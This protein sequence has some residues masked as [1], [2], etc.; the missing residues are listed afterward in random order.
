MATE[1]PAQPLTYSRGDV[2]VRI[3]P[4]SYLVRAKGPKTA[5]LVGLSI[6]YDDGSFSFSGAGRRSDA[7]HRS[8][9]RFAVLSQ[10]AAL[11]LAAERQAAFERHGCPSPGAWDNSRY[12]G[13]HSELQD[14]IATAVAA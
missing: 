7:G 3:D 10:G 13:Y 9:A 6:D 1:Q 11:D 5:I 12:L 4:T 2:L 8:S 14:I